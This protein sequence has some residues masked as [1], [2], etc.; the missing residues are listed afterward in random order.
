MV[1]AR[2]ESMTGSSPALEGNAARVRKGLH[3]RL[4]PQL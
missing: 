1:P 3:P 4:P 2:D